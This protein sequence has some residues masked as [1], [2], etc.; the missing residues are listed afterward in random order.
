MFIYLVGG[1]FISFP[2]SLGFPKFK[3][4]LRSRDVWMITVLILGY[5]CDLT[6]VLPFS[7]LAG[8]LKEIRNIDVQYC[9]R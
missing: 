6:V 3:I 4:L 9:N 7:V 5:P 1:F 2:H 8:S